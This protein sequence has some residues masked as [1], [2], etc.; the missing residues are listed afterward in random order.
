MPTKNPGLE[1]TLEVTGKT[2]RILAKDIVLSFLFGCDLIG[3]QK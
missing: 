2:A 3:S 1:F